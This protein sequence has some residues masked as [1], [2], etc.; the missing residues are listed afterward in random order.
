M[1]RPRW[2]ALQHLGEGAAVERRSQV[3][4]SRILAA[5]V[6]MVMNVLDVVTT[7]M[8]L[9]RGGVEANPI[10]AFLI[11]YRV[12]WVAKF[13]VPCWILLFAYIGRARRDRVDERLYAAVWFVAGLYSMIVVSNAL[14]LLFRY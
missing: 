6:I 14:V 3:L 11:E 8:V 1:E 13:L 9:R 2:A 12:L 5:W 4:H 7:S 10:S